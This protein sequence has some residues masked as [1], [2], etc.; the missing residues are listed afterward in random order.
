MLTTLGVGPDM[1]QLINQLSGRFSDLAYTAGDDFSW[2]AEC[3]TVCYP[4]DSLHTRP[5]SANTAKW[6]LLHETAHGL[7][8]HENYRADYELL[9]MEIA[10]WERAIELAGDY[11][12]TIDD[13]H[14]QDCLDTYRDWLYQRSLCPNCGVQCLQQADYKH[15]GCFNCHAV[16]SVSA[17]RFTRTYRAKR[18]AELT[19]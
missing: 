11:E 9:Q 16:W 6:S 10:A 7:L 3:S 17:N 19:A 14:I 2:S 13:D 18:L 15:Y 4:A 12:I 1:Q 5:D 8:G